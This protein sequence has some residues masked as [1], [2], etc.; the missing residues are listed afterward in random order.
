MR[1]ADDSIVG[2]AHRHEAEKF[3]ADLKA[4]FPALA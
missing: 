3:L 2:F 1:Y 4:S